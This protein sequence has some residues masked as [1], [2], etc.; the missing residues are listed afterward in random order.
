MLFLYT[1]SL[2][3]LVVKYRHL[4]FSLVFNKNRPWP[5]SCKDWRWVC[6]LYVCFLLCDTHVAV[7]RRKRRWQE[8]D[9]CPYSILQWCEWS[10]PSEEF[11]GRLQVLKI[12]IHAR[13]QWTQS[14]MKFHISPFISFHLS[15]SVCFL[16]KI[17]YYSHTSYNRSATAI[18]HRTQ[19]HNILRSP[20]CTQLSFSLSLSLLLSSFTFYPHYYRY[21]HY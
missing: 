14:E 19:L 1:I 8:G 7:F 17:Y 6:F 4:F 12:G 11:E 2:I 20:L 5:W 15:F 9:S 3:T 16:T 18:I 10:P 21:F 13:P